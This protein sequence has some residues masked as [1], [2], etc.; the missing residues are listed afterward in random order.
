[1][2]FGNRLRVR[3]C[4]ICVEED[5]I[6]LVRHRALGREGVLWAPP[7][8]GMHF[9][10]SAGANL[11]REFREET[12]LTVS[13]GD[14]ICTHEFLEPPLHAIELFFNV[15]ISGGSLRTGTDPEMEPSAQIIDE[16]RFVPF[17]EIAHGEPA[18]YHNILRICSDLSKI[19]DL[20]GYLIFD[21]NQ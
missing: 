15:S 3:V 14:F 12:G 19:Q 10:Q 18:Q 4:G 6:L 5:R 16:V 7:G 1:M 9:G 17:D 11:V 21:K 8:G 13:V 2:N 20:R